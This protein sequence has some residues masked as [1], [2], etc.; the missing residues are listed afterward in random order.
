M[1]GASGPELAALY[2]RGAAWLK[3]KKL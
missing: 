1:P 2:R 3:G